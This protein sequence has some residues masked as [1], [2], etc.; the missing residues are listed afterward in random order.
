MPPAEDYL[1][2]EEVS[3]SGNFKN[4][5]LN[6]KLLSSKNPVAIVEIPDPFIFINFFS[7][8]SKHSVR[9]GKNAVPNS[10]S[11][12]QIQDIIT[13]SKNGMHPFRMADTPQKI[14]HE[15]NELAGSIYKVLTSN[16]RNPPSFDQ[17][18]PELV[19]LI[20]DFEG[21][22]EGA[23]QKS[24]SEHWRLVNQ[25]L[26]HYVK[27]KTD[28][29]RYQAWNGLDPKIR[30]DIR[31]KSEKE[32]NVIRQKFVKSL[33]DKLMPQ[34]WVRQGAGATGQGPSYQTRVERGNG[35]IQELAH[36]VVPPQPPHLQRQQEMIRLSPGGVNN[37]SNENLSEVVDP[38]IE[39]LII[40]GKWEIKKIDD[41]YDLILKAYIPNYDQMSPMQKDD[42]KVK[43]LHTRINEGRNIE[44]EKLT[45]SLCKKVYG[46]LDKSPWKW[47]V[48][49][50]KYSDAPIIKPYSVEILK[51]SVNQFVS[52]SLA[53][54]EAK[55]I[56]DSKKKSLTER[57][58]SDLPSM[59]PPSKGGI[60]SETKRLDGLLRSPSSFEQMRPEIR[61]LIEN[62]QDRIKV[63]ESDSLEK[64]WDL[65]KKYLPQYDQLTPQ[66]RNTPKNLEIQNNANEESQYEVKRLRRELKDGIHRIFELP[67]SQWADITL[68]YSD[69]LG[70]KPYKYEEHNDTISQFIRKAFEV[71]ENVEMQNVP[72]EMRN[73]IN[74][75]KNSD[76][77][78]KNE[79]FTHSLENSKLILQNL[80]LLSVFI[81]KYENNIKFISKIPHLKE[82]IKFLSEDLY[83]IKNLNAAC[84]GLITV[85]E[86]EEA[87]S[88]RRAQLL[89]MPT[90]HR[91]GLKFFRSLI[92]YR[93]MEPREIKVSHLSYNS[94]ADY[95]GKFINIDSRHLRS[96]GWEAS[97]VIHEL[98]HCVEAPS[99]SILKSSVEFRARR[100]RE[101]WEKKGGTAYSDKRYTDGEG[102]DTSSEVLSVGVTRIFDD[103]VEFFEKDPEYCAYV[104][105]TLRGMGRMDF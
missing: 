82:N 60:S 26:P 64:Y 3:F 16:L 15:R 20:L 70:T 5:I 74:W 34:L 30:N 2:K 89:E 99:A 24:V 9:K 80:Q 100:T 78:R 36:S 63:A 54:T 88:S 39:S 6:Q 44:K 49:V 53:K 58:L 37:I 94:S 90:E 68:S 96:S 21:Q 25:Y 91:V 72:K 75:L 48:M 31:E 12:Q 41:Q 43:I 69:E 50:L 79:K 67:K 11:S 38:E 7:S 92:S 73:T 32:L 86:W 8:D 76:F 19:P 98:A 59:P 47:D 23:A 29:E 65:I 55:Q 45:Q 52:E 61:A 22:I 87:D 71:L 62:Y 35:N 27:L 1:G 102:R 33:S 17:M 85:I 84:N 83:L 77:L 81:I 13:L 57:P 10:L 4:K 95:A 104:I 56:Q 93:V 28:E 42:N 103:P 40:P 18:R 46:I 101:D 14:V 66:E 105:N 97:A 51:K